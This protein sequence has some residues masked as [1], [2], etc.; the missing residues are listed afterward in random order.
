MKAP[1]CPCAPVPEAAF[2]AVRTRTIFD[3]CKWD[4]QV[5]DVPVLSPQPVVLAADVWQTLGRDAEALYRE[6]VAAETAL[7]ARPDLH[8]Q[9]GLPRAVRRL[10]ARAGRQGPCPAAARVFRF[11]FHATTEGWCVSEVNADVPGGY[12]EASGFTQIMHAHYPHLSL[13][14]D[15]AAA[16]AAALARVVRLG[17]MIGLVHATAYT[18]D[19][20]VM[21]FLARRL[22]AQGLSTCLLSPATLT[23]VDGCAAAWDDTGPKPLDALVRFFPAE[24]LP[25]LPRRTGWT[26]FFVGAHTPQS[27]PATVLLVQSKRL[28]LVWEALGADCPTWRRLLP[29]TRAPRDVLL[30]DGEW[31]LKPTLGR[32]GEGIAMRGVTPPRVWQCAARSARWWPRAWVAQRRFVPLAWDTASGPRFPCIGVYVIDGVTAGAY[33]RLGRTPLVDHTAEDAALL[34]AP[35]APQPGQEVRHDDTGRGLCRVGAGDGGLVA[36]GEAG[37]VCGA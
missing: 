11:D 24:W 23:W 32:V 18:D 34:I 7:L 9:L 5:E 21:V 28:P 10:L 20:Q 6:T 29:E 22:A 19:R 27:N 12:V 4:P 2:R 33:V 26:H 35:S 17:G 1:W 13:P 37:A 16:L 36:L 14:R 25:N 3:C 31:L 8:A 30:A 15:P